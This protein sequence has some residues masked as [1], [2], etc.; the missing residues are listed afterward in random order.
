VFGLSRNVRFDRFDR[1]YISEGTRKGRAAW[2]VA[3]VAGT[4]KVLEHAPLAL[5]GPQVGWPSS[6]Q[7]QGCYGLC[8]LGAVPPPRWH[9]RLPR[10]RILISDCSRVRCG[11]AV[12]RLASLVDCCDA[13]HTH[14]DDCT[15]GLGLERDHLDDGHV[16][17]AARDW[18]RPPDGNGLGDARIK[19]SLKSPLTQHRSHTRPS[20]PRS[21]AQ[22]RHVDEHAPTWENGHGELACNP[23]LDL[24]IGLPFLT[25]LPISH[26]RPSS[27]VPPKNPPHLHFVSVFKGLHRYKSATPW[28]ASGGF[29]WRKPMKINNKWRCG[30]FYP[31]PGGAEA[32]CVTRPGHDASSLSSDK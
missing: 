5:D 24:L 32:K 21:V 20:T 23:A 13:T 18:Q 28:S 26:F 25:P 2:Q 7:L 6:R 19:P 22:G 10:W 17:E 3:F 16:S 12:H 27:P 4:A 8:D 15:P 29:F 14:A 30:G 11:R 9:P 31:L 1:S